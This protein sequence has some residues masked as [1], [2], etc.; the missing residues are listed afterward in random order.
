MDK[1]LQNLLRY[2]GFP[3]P[4]ARPGEPLASALLEAAFLVAAAD[5]LLSTS[6]AELLQAAMSFVRGQEIGAA[7][8]D[9]TLEHFNEIRSHDGTDSRLVHISSMLDD[10]SQ[11]GQV[12]R[13]AVA[14]ALC[15][16]RVVPREHGTLL[17]LGKA[18]GFSPE[19]VFRVQEEVRLAAL[20]DP[21]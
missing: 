3:T 5:D 15:D 18:L 7:E 6:E 20:L 16:R 8:L 14:V 11:R 1:H 10:P 21:S 19:E 13:F 2:V 12:L 17:K 4:T 9:A